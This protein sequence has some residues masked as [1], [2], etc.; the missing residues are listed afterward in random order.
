MPFLL[1]CRKVS[2]CCWKMKT[3]AKQKKSP[4]QGKKKSIVHKIG[5][6]PPKSFPPC[7]IGDPNGSPKTF[8]LVLSDRAQPF[9]PDRLQAWW[10]GKCSRCFCALRQRNGEGEGVAKSP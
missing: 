9:W 8:S 4:S 6:T 2:D 1:L 5:N 3:K 7:P 10:C